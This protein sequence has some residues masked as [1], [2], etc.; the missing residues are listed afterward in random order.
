MVCKH[1]TSV[2][3]S[4][5]TVCSHCDTQIHTY[6][7]MNLSDEHWNNHC[8]EYIRI[9]IGKYERNWQSWFSFHYLFSW[10]DY[11][12]LARVRRFSFDIWHASG[13]IFATREPGGG[14]FLVNHMPAVTSRYKPVVLLSSFLTSYRVILS[15][16]LGY[17]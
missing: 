4:I 1:D 7:W 13:I 8:V 3:F 6:I 5:L 17:L 16:W 2:S 9:S 14:I 15:R 11:L 12:F 10:N